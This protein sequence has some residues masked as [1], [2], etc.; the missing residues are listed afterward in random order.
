MVTKT[1]QVF[2]YVSSCRIA[3]PPEILRRL[4]AN[5]PESA[6][7]TALR[8]IDRLIPVDLETIVQKCVARFPADRY[9]TA[10][11]VAEDL[12]RFCDHRPI[13]ATPT[14][15]M[16]SIRQWIRRNRRLSTAI[17]V[18]S[19]ALLTLAIVGPLA[20]LRQAELLD[21]QR[22]LTAQVEEEKEVSEA[23]T[24]NVASNSCTILWFGLHLRTPTKGA[25]VERP[26]SSNA[27]NSEMTSFE[28]SL[29]RN[30][31]DSDRNRTLAK[32]W[33]N[34]TANRDSS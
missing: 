2:R 7:P 8:Q 15:T 21:D 32:H 30:R 10:A 29:L 1:L 28:F 14:R 11:D 6:D 16:Q 18:A 27:M 17:A 4:L 20:A 34:I 3:A 9:T 5:S 23:G 13:T 22:S 33:C 25:F 24:P 31:L 19:C 12:Q 26:K